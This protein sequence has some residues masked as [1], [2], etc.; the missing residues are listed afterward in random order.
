MKPLADKKNNAVSSNP[1]LHE[2]NTPFNT[3]PF[4]EIRHEHFVPAFNAGIEQGLKE[5]DGIVNNPSEPGFENTIATLSRSGQTLSRVSNVFYPLSN[6]ETDATMQDIARQVAPLLADY[7]NDILF[8]PGLFE[9]VKA[10]YEKRNMLSLNEE[11]K[12]LLDKTWKMFVRNGAGLDAASK[13]RLREISRELSQLSLKFDDNLLAETNE[14]FL[15]LTSLDELSGLPESQREAAA[16]EARKRGLE[17]WVVTLKA[18]SMWPFLQYADRRDLRE[19]VFRAANR[20]GFNGNQYDNRE[21]VKQI[22]NLRLERAKVLG[23]DTHAHFVLEEQMAGSPQKVMDFL[24]ELLHAA[25]PKALKDLEEVQ[26]LAQQSGEP[27]PIEYWDWYY[28]AE[29]MRK[30]RYDFDQ[31]LLRP[32]F[33]LNSVVKGIFELAHRLWGLHFVPNQEIPVYHPEVTAYEVYDEQDTFLAILFLDFFPRE[34]KSPGAWMTGFR[35]QE[36]INGRDLRPQVSL[37][38]NFTRP[39]ATKPSLLTHGEFNTFLHEFGHALHGMFSQVTFAE[40]SGTNVYR[41][42]VELPS[43]IMENWAV[44]SEYLDLFARHYQTG[45]KIPAEMVEKI[46]ATQNFHA[47]FAAMRQLGFGFND[48]VWHTI[49]E[50]V[51]IAANEFEAAAMAP[52]RLFPPVSDTMISGSFAHIFAGGYAAGYYSYKWAEVLDADAFRLFKERGIFDK[53]T[54]AAFREHILSKGGSEH[55]MTLYKRFRGS[56]PTLDAL[57][58]REGLR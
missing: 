34:G 40:L 28:Y 19:K 15:H 51:S 48:M 24:N 52:A 23:Y 8:H 42:F 55:P 44:E 30:A 50:P 14:W 38:C 1:F 25:R 9:R 43:Q 53:K 20:R 36:R 56:E 45:E 29:K 47:A 27:H 33:E 46:V 11:E 58:E 16:E 26:Q 7:H 37:V 21:I 10:V 17:G 39:T 18:P 2:F 5:I 22:A 3:P 4:G 32:F 6:A 35:E 49:R 54:A 12:T 41:D 57:L 31:E 13:A